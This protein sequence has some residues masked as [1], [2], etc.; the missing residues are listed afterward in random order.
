MARIVNATQHK[1]SYSE[2]KKPVSLFNTF[3]VLLIVNASSTIK[4]CCVVSRIRNNC[5]I[6]PVHLVLFSPHMFC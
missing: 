2:G 3:V 1:P 5:N 4:S 6:G